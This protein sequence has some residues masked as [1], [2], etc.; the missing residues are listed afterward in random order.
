MKRVLF[1]VM[2]V[3]VAISAYDYGTAADH[4]VLVVA[5]GFLTAMFLIGKFIE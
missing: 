5:G 1:L 2:A 3:I 4:Y